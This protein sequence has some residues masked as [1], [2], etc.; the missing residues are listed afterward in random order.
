[1]DGH[2]PIS[3]ESARKLERSFEVVLYYVV[4]LVILT[5]YLPLGL[6]INH[7]IINIVALTTV[8]LSVVAYRILPIEY[9]DGLAS[10][11][12]EIKSFVIII[13]DLIFTA[14]VIGATGGGDGPYIF[15]Y[16]FLI[17][18]AS[19]MLHAIHMYILIPITL[20]SLVIADYISHPEN[21]LQPRL[22][23]NLG[24]L[25]LLYWL[26]IIIVKRKR[27]EWI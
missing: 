13:F 16:A 23:I 10:Y 2:I 7:A 8:L 25:I 19:L 11:T 1:M 15:L 18:A 6:A 5:S 24:M 3:I 26:A 27:G 17:L 4:A 9:H 20:I 21:T 12:F 22:L 14:F